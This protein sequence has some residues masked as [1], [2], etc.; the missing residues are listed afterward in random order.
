MGDAQVVDGA[1]P[2]RVVVRRG[3]RS[4]AV[5]VVLIGLLSV[6]LWWVEEV[7][8]RRADQPLGLD[9]AAE[10][11]VSI[12]LAFDRLRPGEVDAY[13]GPAV[14]VEAARQRARRP[15]VLLAEAEALASL[16]DRAPFQDGGRR[17]RLAADVQ[18]L[19]ARLQ[20]T[21]RGTRPS[22]VQEATGT[23]GLT[24]APPAAVDVLA[25]RAALDAALPAGPA[26]GARLAT[27][28]TRLVV[29]VDRRRDVFL[30]ALEA[31]RAATVPHWPLPADE[32]LD[33]AWTSSGAAAWHRYLGGHRSRLDV[34]PAG[35]ALLDASVDVA[36]HE[37][38]PGHHAQFVLHDRGA[39]DRLPLEQQ[40]VLLRSPAAV[41]REG[42]AQ[43][44][45]QLAFPPEARRTLERDVLAPLA[46]VDVGDVERQQVLRPHLRVLE[47]LVPV[48]LGAWDRGDIDD[49]EAVRRLADEALVAD[50]PSVLRFAREHGAY[51]FAYTVARARV[52]GLVTAASD[53]TPEGA[54]RALRDLLAP[55]RPERLAGR[56]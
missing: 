24:L 18:V 22:L 28:R 20:A 46:G 8:G 3:V 11:Y 44:G 41:L 49:E 39:E 16:L 29:P 9:E 27:H 51:V 56:W 13:F 54:W 33:L 42:A 21:V 14:H 52:E 17:T 55:P 36:C 34:N 31:C 26:L 7:P 5:L 43:Y 19:V 40:L 35:V 12:A 32:H 53:G 2:T 23:Y 50:A 30:R 15:D 47:R 10:R 25:A 6:A 1:G 48:I 38:Y 37:G 45:V 4:L